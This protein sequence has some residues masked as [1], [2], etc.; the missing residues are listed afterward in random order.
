MV[1]L[2]EDIPE[3]LQNTILIAQRCN[4]N[5][6]LGTACL[7]DFPVPEGVGLENF[8][9]QES[10]KGLKEHWQHVTSKEYTYEDYQSRLDF[11]LNVINQMGFPGYFLIVADFIRWAKEIAERPA[12]KRGTRVNRAPSGPEDSAI[13]ERHDSSDLDYDD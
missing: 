12:F 5:L 6:T 13:I 2:F 10:E 8:L 4:V 7:P 1:S 3:A 11:E 9:R